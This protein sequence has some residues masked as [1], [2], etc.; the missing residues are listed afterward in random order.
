MADNPKNPIEEW[1]RLGGWLPRK[2]VELVAFRKDLAKQPQQRPRGA[3][4]GGAQFPSAP[5]TRTRRRTG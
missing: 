3:R 1:R 5:A 4:A 2:E